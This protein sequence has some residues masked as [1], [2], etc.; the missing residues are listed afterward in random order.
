MA[1]QILRSHRA[2]D[3]RGPHGLEMTLAN[4]LFALGVARCCPVDDLGSD[5]RRFQECR[6][7]G[8]R[9]SRLS[10]EIA[11]FR[12]LLVSHGSFRVLAGQTRR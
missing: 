1:L 4:A 8:S 2:W 5:R 3:Q 11:E 9:R 10:S 6:V 7:L 12:W